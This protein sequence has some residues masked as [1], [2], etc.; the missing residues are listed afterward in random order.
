MKTIYILALGEIDPT[1]V[2]AIKTEVTIIFQVPTKVLATVSNP[3]Y[4]FDQKRCQYYSTKILKEITAQLPDDGL[5]ILGITEVDLCTPVLTFVFGE[6]H[7]K[8]VS[9]VISLARLRQE[10]YQLPT[11]KTL[12]LHRAV[13]EA[14]HELGHTFGLVHCNDKQCVICFSPNVL[15]V[16]HKGHGFCPMCQQALA[17]RLVEIIEINGKTTGEGR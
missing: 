8:G 9:A 3:A 11:N 12:L 17:N 2:N 7:L 13:K 10:F 14:V 16:D 5:R 1:I 4:A 6:A 15:S